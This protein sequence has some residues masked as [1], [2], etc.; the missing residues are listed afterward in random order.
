M[1]NRAGIVIAA[2]SNPG[3]IRKSNEDTF[4]QMT[5][6]NRNSVLAVV[7]DGVGG[8]SNGAMASLICCRDLANAY[9]R[10]PDDELSTPLQAEKFFRDNIRVINRKIFERNYF[11]QLPRPMC[12]TIV[13]CLF[14]EHSIVMASA[15][16]SRFYELTAAGEWLQLSSDHTLSEEYEREFGRP[17]HKKGK[18]MKNVIVRAVG[19]RVDLQPDCRVFRRNPGSRYLLCTD[20]AYGYMAESILSNCIG[21]ASSPREAVNLLMRSVLLSGAYDNATIMVAF[22]AE[23]EAGKP[24][25]AP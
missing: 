4:S 5:A 1:S 13:T 16:D 12:S 23:E 8:H 18:K 25:A 19:P 14:L 15:G 24:D 20:G 22:Q 11:E 9:L 21:S 10:M 7:A 2:E 3:L 17:L 6:E